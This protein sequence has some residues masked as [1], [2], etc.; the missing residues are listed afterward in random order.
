[1]WALSWLKEQ[2]FYYDRG[3]HFDKNKRYSMI[4]LQ[5]YGLTRTPGKIRQC[6]WIKD[7]TIDDTHPIDEELITNSN[8]KHVCIWTKEVINKP[9]TTSPIAN[10]QHIWSLSHLLHVH[11]N[12]IYGTNFLMHI[13]GEIP[14]GVENIN[15]L[16]GVDLVQKIQNK[17]LNFPIG[18]R[19]IRI[20]ISS[21]P[22]TWLVKVLDNLPTTL[23]ILEICK[24]YSSV[25]TE[26]QLLE[27]RLRVPFGCK[28]KFINY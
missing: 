19:K 3:V 1:M 27:E 4:N 5:G 6:P 14:E 23:E 21:C 9:I 8:I 18:T 28:M 17:T 7:I 24:K 10:L 20:N 22:N 13:F 2:Y 11:T 26:K 12:Y 25:A 16:W 15:I